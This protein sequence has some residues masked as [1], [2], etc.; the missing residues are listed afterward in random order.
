MPDYDVL[1]EQTLALVPELTAVA[2]AA[3][4]VEAVRRL[5]LARQRLEDGRLTVVVCGEFKRGKSS[6]LNALLEEPGLFPVDDYYATSLVTTVTYGSE[7]RVTVTLDGVDGTAEEQRRVERAELGDYVTEAGNPGNGKGV[8]SVLVETP[9]P[10]LASGLTLV[11]TPGVGGVH[12]AH[13]AAT[14]AMLPNADVVLFVTDV[15]PL[16]DSELRF[17]RRAAVTVR[18]VDDEDALLFVLTKIDQVADYGPVLADT[19]GKIAAATG[20]AEDRVPLVPVSTQAKLN[21]LAEPDQGDLAMSNFAELERLIWGAL[22]RRRARLLLGGALTDL[23]RSAV[24]LLQ[25]VEAEAESLRAREA[26]AIEALQQAL[27]ARQRRLAALEAGDAEWRRTL[28]RRV[29]DLCREV[30]ARTLAGLEEVWQRLGED[31]LSSDELLD[32]TDQ[33]LK[34]L[35]EDVTAVLAAAGKLL[36]DGAASLQGEFEKQN[37]LVLGRPEVSRLPEAPAPRLPPRTPPEPRQL[38]EQP[39]AVIGMWWDGSKNGVRI[40][41]TLGTTVGRLV[42]P[43]IV[44][45]PGASTVIGTGLGVA[46]G[47]LVGSAVDFHQAIRAA[48]QQAREV[49]RTD[50]LTD[51][52]PWYAA[53]QQH[54]RRAV[55]AA[56]DDLADT[57]VVELESRILQERDSAEGAVLRA[58]QARH[59]SAAEV[60]ARE[61]ELANERARLDA[62]RERVATLSRYVARL[63][64]PEPPQLAENAQMEAGVTGAVVPGEGG[65]G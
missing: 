51:L 10:R 40:G 12:T 49:R 50:L 11:D 47:G 15:E 4:A 29:R 53:Q 7:E 54:V 30:E 8:R 31:Y 62:L 13:T 58:H 16:T 9:N 35:A 65:E 18:V 26:D 25:P 28:S 59:R 34:T 41:A 3:G 22:A 24:A 57:I 17:L 45:I 6:L 63:A 2:E 19:R 46:I 21:H 56:A 48:Q 38:R 44:P 5:D 33:L 37:E 52:Q 1:R 14:T 39:K 32:D 42:I 23:D 55:D 60:R 43:F 64:A 20:R 61:P 27:A 36:E